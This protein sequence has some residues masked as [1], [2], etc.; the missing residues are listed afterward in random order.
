MP[1]PTVRHPTNGVAQQSPRRN[2]HGRFGG[3][4]R[5]LKRSSKRLGV[6][7]GGPG[8][9][10]PQLADQDVLVCGISVGISLIGNSEARSVRC[11]RLTEAAVLAE[12]V[13]GGC[14]D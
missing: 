5:Q 6:H 7:E 13:T 12:Q 11:P 3:D 2:K 4:Q 8:R 14:H 10:G 1:R 9:C